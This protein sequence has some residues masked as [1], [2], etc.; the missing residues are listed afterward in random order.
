LVPILKL[1]RGYEYY[2]NVKQNQCKDDD[3][4]LF[5]LTENPV[6]EI[7]GCPPKKLKGSFDATGCGCVKFFVDCCTPKYFYYQNANG[8]FQGNLVIVSDCDC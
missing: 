1:Q 2:F 3:K 6:G 5:V 7:N 8:S 4:N